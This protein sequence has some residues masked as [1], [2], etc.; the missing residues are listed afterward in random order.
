MGTTKQKPIVDT[1]NTLKKKEIKAYHYRKLSYHKGR[2]KDR[3]KGKMDL[4]NILRTNKKIAMIS[5]Y[6][7]AMTLN[8]YG[9]KFQPKDIEL[10]QVTKEV[11]M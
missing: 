9:L 6:L 1:K 2:Q 8:V 5:S 10:E 4:Q 7:S 11:I 3:K